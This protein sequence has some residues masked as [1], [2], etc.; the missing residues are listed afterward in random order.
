M[1]CDSISPLGTKPMRSH[2]IPWSMHVEQDIKT[3]W[4][5]RLFSSHNHTTAFFLSLHLLFTMTSASKCKV[6]LLAEHELQLAW[7]QAEQEAKQ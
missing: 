7:E 6:Q 2:E 1:A 4:A 5:D 3:R